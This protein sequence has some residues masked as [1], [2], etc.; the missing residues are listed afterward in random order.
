MRHQIQA[1]GHAGRSRT[2]TRWSVLL[3]G[4]LLLGALVACGQGTT[5]AVTPTDTTA[6]TATV[7]PTATATIAPTATQTAAH[8]IV[9]VTP[10]PSRCG[11]SCATYTCT[12]PGGASCNELL[13]C[14]GS[15]AVTSFPFFEVDNSGQEP[16]TWSW[17]I[18]PM[19]SGSNMATLTLS[20][21]GGTVAGGAAVAVTL[22]A[23]K[24][25][26]S[27]GPGA[28]NINFTGGGVTATVQASCSNG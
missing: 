26:A 28:F 2:A 14:S 6:P 1:D 27:N 19:G 13:F 21:N 7:P 20:P 22:T 12:P 16:L 18:V 11:T 4:V 15:P 9:R 3:A 10:D 24:S 23:D 25:L 5:I 8:M 17:T